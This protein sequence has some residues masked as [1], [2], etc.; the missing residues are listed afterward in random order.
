MIFSK[1]LSD[2][3]ESRSNGVYVELP[4]FSTNERIYV[5]KTGELFHVQYWFDGTKHVTPTNLTSY[6]ET[7]D[8]WY[9][10]P[11]KAKVP[12]NFSKGWGW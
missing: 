5:S 3:H 10:K 12:A 8:R 9:I 7:D 1:I 4:E 2:L 11:F 6:E